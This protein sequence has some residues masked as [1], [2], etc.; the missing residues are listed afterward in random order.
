MWSISK[1]LKCSF[2][3]DQNLWTLW[4]LEIYLNL[5]LWLVSSLSLDKQVQILL[6]NHTIVLTE[7][8][9]N[10]LWETNWCYDQTIAISEPTI[11]HKKWH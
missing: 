2:L 5:F 11:S 3:V 9:S 4:V 8:I 7:N 6:Q 10:V 1:S